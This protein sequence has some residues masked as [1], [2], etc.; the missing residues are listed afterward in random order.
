MGKENIS[1]FGGDPERITVAG[2]SGGAAGTGALHASPLMKGLIQR[3]SIESGPVYWGFMKPQPMAVM[4]QRGIEFMRR[5]DCQSIAQLR[6]KDAWELFDLYEEFASEN[7]GMP[8]AF[9]FCV[10]GAFLPAIV[11]TLPW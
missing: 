5:A 6:Q 2:Q 9:S 4:E 10:D 11:D 8:H 1:Q 3:V 7:G